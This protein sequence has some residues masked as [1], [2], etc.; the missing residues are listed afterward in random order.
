[1]CLVL[2]APSN[3]RTLI[4]MY[5]AADNFY[6]F[7]D[8]KDIGLIIVAAHFTSFATESFRDFSSFIQDYSFA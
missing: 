6:H 1:M 8:E 2:L 4:K 5:F 7:T 3:T